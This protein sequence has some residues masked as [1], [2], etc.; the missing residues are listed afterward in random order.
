M[1]RM[2][3]RQLLFCQRA[4]VCIALPRSF[5]AAHPCATEPARVCSARFEAVFITIGHHL[6]RLFFISCHNTSG[7]IPYQS[8]PPQWTSA[9]VQWRVPHHRLPR[10][11]PRL[12]S[13]IFFKRCLQNDLF[14]QR[15]LFKLPRGLL[16]LLG[17]GLWRNPAVA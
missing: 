8:H 10:T 2:L 11:M 7:R 6:S 12:L 13:T 1:I 9:F 17:L 16:Q 3:H 4:L 14:Q 15:L 5:T